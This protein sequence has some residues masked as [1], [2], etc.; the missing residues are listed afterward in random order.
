MMEVLEFKEPK[1]KNVLKMLLNFLKEKGITNTTCVSKIIVTNSK[2]EIKKSFNA[3]SIE[4]ILRN[5]V[6][7]NAYDEASDVLKNIDIHNKDVYV[8]I[9][10]ANEVLRHCKT[11]INNEK[12]TQL[13]EKIIGCL[14]HLRSSTPFLDLH[15]R[16][17]I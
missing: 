3:S 2:I 10:E 16:M 9:R 17:F 1:D 6:K 4:S 11:E 15:F 12:A 14:I 13:K 8:F 7:N 5:V